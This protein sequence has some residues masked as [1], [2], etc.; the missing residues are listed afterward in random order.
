MIGRVNLDDRRALGRS[1]GRLEHAFGIWFSLVVVARDRDDEA[2]PR[3]WDQQVRTVRVLGH[4]T[5]AMEAADGADSVW[6]DCRRVERERAAETIALHP[7]APAAIGLIL[8]VE[9]G[10]EC[11]RVLVDSRIRESRTQAHD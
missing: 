3:L 7:C 1:E 6:S 10:D 4:E 5:A 9:E 8:L 11:R 2:R